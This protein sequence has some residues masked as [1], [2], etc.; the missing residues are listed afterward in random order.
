LI[1]RKSFKRRVRRA[2]ER[3]SDDRFIHFRVHHDNELVGGTIVAPRHNVFAEERLILNSLLQRLV[4][5]WR[6]RALPAKAV[7]F[8]LV[9]VVNTLIDANVFAIA[10]G[11][12]EIPLI[13]ANGLA[14][15]VAVSFSYAANAVTT[16]GPESGQVLTIRDYLRFVMSGAVGGLVATTALVIAAKFVPVITAKLISIFA[17]FAANFLL[18]NFFVF[19]SK[20]T[21][22]E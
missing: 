7:S 19:R 10:Y 14:W 15:L 9:G 6:S 3:R 22:S 17:G 16:F 18:S 20:R 4:K 13:P 8:A 12:F 2:F 21:N 1:L 5:A 11:I